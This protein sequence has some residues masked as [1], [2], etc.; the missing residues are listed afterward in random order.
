MNGVNGVML[1]G[2]NGNSIFLPFTGSYDEDGTFNPS[3]S[4]YWESDGVSFQP[5]TAYCAWLNSDGLSIGE[6]WKY[7]GGSIRPIAIESS[8]TPLQLSESSIDITEGDNATVQIT[9]GSGSYSVTSSNENVATAAIDGSLVTITAVGEGTA[10]ITVTDTQSGETAIIRVTVSP[11]APPM[12]TSPSPSEDA[13]NV[14]TRGTFSWTTIPDDEESTLRYELFLDTDSSSVYSNSEVYMVGQGN[15]C[16]FSGLEPNTKYYWKVIVFNESGGHTTSDIWSFTTRETAPSSSS[17]R[18]DVNG[19]RNVTVADVMLMVNYVLQKSINHFLVKNADVN[20]DGKVTVTDIMKTI[21]IIMSGQGFNKIELPEGANINVS[22]L[23]VLNDGE[24][25]TVDNAGTFSTADGDM[26]AFNGDSLV[27][28]SYGSQDDCRTLNSQETAI[29]LLL[30]LIPYAVTDMDDDSFW[31]L[32]QMIGHLEQTRE[33][34]AAID[35][36]IIDKGYLDMAA[37]N[38]QYV[39]AAAEVHR[40]LGFDDS[41]PAHSR[42]RKVKKTSY[43]IFVYGN[44]ETYGDGF[45]LVKDH[46]IWGTGDKGDCWKCKFTI[47]NADRWCY[48]SLIK[49]KKNNAGGFDRI[50][51]GFTDTFTNLIKP[52]N[53]SAFMDWGTLSDMAINP[54]DFMSNL[55][56]PDFDRVASLLWEPIKNFGHIIKGEDTEISSFDKIKKS[57]IEFD[58][59]PDSE[60]LAI[61][62]PGDDLKLFMFNFVKIGVCPFIKILIKE[63]KKSDD[64]KNEDILDKLMIYFAEWMCKDY[65]FVHEEIFATMADSSKP[66]SER[67]LVPLEKVIA[68]YF[69][70]I[71]DEALVGSVSEFIFKYGFGNLPIGYDDPQV[72]EIFR[73]YKTI[74]TVGDILLF[75]L[76]SQYKGSVFLIDH[77]PSY[78]SYHER[79]YENF[80]VGDVTFTMMKLPGG[81]FMMG[82]EPD[83]KRADGS[84]KPLHYVNLKKFAIGETE[85]TQSLWQAVMGSNPSRFVNGNRPV[86]NVSWLDCQEFITKLNQLTGRTFR[87]PTE[88]EWEFAACGG[89][90]KRGYPYAGG[91]SVDEVAW[92]KNNGSDETHPVR[93]KKAN[94]FGLYDMSGNV[95][96]WCQDFYDANYYGHSPEEN[97]CNDATASLYARVLRGGSWHWDDKYCRVSS[98]NNNAQGVKAEQFG[99]RLAMDVSD[100]PQ[101]YLT[102]PDDHHPH[103]IDLGLPSGTKWA[104]C[105]VG[106]TTPT[107]YGG[108]YAWGET[109]EKDYYDWSTY[110]HCDGSQA[111]C[112][113]LGSDIAG[114]Q[115]DVAHVKWGGSWVMPSKAQQD[116]LRENCSSEWTTVNGVNGRIFT[117]SNGG[118]IFLPAAGYRWD[119]GLNDVGSDGYN[120]SSTQAPSYSD[121]AYGLCL[122]FYSG[123]VYWG[124]CG[125]GHGLSVRP[126]SR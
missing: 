79:Q 31:L 106:A 38:P 66:F 18:G 92:Y 73:I 48:T 30:P 25:V 16:R 77:G 70:F 75:N 122:F 78:E 55:S 27:Y 33:L 109:E 21:K 36:S 19:D 56:D 14:A 99:L 1:T 90:Y 97:P 64:Y 123:R 86:D 111:T 72:K 34:A 9:S 76:H 46:T 87:L 124:Y 58:L 83:D 105:N 6:G 24:Q 103:M 13:D 29:S 117:G 44:K 125:R 11:V 94:E 41:E 28:I 82:A 114:T 115:Y 61:L 42:M 102:C 59:Y 68:K 4:L 7:T 89:M 74:L 12:P 69:N 5:G 60:Q 104:C 52:M 98:R 95:M 118:S 23:T 96:E 62:G 108:Y 39:A 8:A 107:G 65:T 2:S 84:E 81:P 40:R 119:D 110:I 10:T 20:D 57:G 101:A 53:V 121:D 116:E 15:T 112:H 85:V 35:Q 37:V 54:K 113:N 51:D 50:D 47:F 93:L 67:F 91:E 43:P 80:T 63:Y 49:T 17:I 22:N 71:K 100:T 3:N 126:V 45:T 32:K 120:W 88:A 26:M